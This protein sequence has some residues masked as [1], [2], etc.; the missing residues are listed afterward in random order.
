MPYIFDMLRRIASGFAKARSIVREGGKSRN[1]S[2]HWNELRDEYLSLHP[3]CAACGGTFMLQVH[4]VVPFSIAAGLELDPTNL[5]TL[6][7]GEFDC[8]LKLGHGG[9][10]RYYNPHVRSIAAEFM[11]GSTGT[12]LVLLRKAERVRLR[13]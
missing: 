12:R 11:S 1:R 8:H 9:S 7:M 13:D 10:F 6:C 2:A 5:L 4:H 3:S